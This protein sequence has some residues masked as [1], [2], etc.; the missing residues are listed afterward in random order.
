LVTLY[1]DNTSPFSHGV[2]LYYKSTENYKR[3]TA[4]TRS[5]K[6]N[7]NNI[8]KKGSKSLEDIGGLFEA[9]TIHAWRYLW[10]SRD[11]NYSDLRKKTEHLR[12]TGGL[13]QWPNYFNMTKKSKPLEVIGDLL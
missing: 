4:Q 8:S 12:D 7:K 6:I 10:S 2:S 11:H 1:N 13:N 9:G 3:H 5:N